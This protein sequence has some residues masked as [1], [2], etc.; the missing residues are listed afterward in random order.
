MKELKDSH[1]DEL[2]TPNYMWITF[3]SESTIQAALD[4]NQFNFDEH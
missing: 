3:K 4:A 1:L 2:N